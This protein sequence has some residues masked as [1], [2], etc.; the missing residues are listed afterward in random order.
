MLRNRFSKEYWR[1]HRS[2]SFAR[3]ALQRGIL[4]K[5]FWF[6]PDGNAANPSQ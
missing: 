6:E 3:L 4:E 2:E 5:C 1:D